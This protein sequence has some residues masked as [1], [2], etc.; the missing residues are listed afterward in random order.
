MIFFTVALVLSKRFKQALKIRAIRSKELRQWARA[1]PA[2]Q[3]AAWENM[4]I[5]AQTRV[6][7]LRTKVLLILAARFTV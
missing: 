5:G 1:L 6:A 2:R 4:L 3:L 7:L